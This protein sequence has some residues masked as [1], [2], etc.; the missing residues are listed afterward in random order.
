MVFGLR[1][2]LEIVGTG[3]IWLG[4]LGTILWYYD[5]DV[6]E[7]CWLEL[8]YDDH[9]GLPVDTDKEGCANGRQA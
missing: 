7:V 2:A 9:H 4:R 1:W 8:L 5:L 3:R 6:H